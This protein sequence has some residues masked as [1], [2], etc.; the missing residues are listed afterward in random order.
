[1]EY[2]NFKSLLRCVIVVP[3]LVTASLA[4]LLLWETFDLN[5]SLQWVDHTDRVLDQSGNLLK[6]LAD[7]ESAKTGYIVTGDE[8][9]L[10]PYLEG[11]K[12][13]D[14]EFQALNQLVDDSPSQQQRLKVV[15]AGYQESEEYDSRIIALRRAGKAD[16]T[17][18]ENQLRNHKMETLRDQIAEFQGAEKTLR[19]E[20]VQFAHQRWTYIVTSCLFLGL[21]SGVFLAL[22]GRYHVEKLGTKL[23]QSE[24]RWTATLG[25]IG[26][27]VIATDSE[28]RITFLNPIAAALT[29]WEQEEALNQPIGN[30]LRLINEKSD[31]KSNV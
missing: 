14:P 20:R 13:F 3:M 12:R 31:R 17:L 7:M 19:I 26:E 21:G 10:L 11:T 24:E 23:L 6:L 5:R 30:V 9:F 27:A 15:Y 18:I 16:P 4:G 25:S 1:M 28:G 8:T 29:G 22:F 2:S